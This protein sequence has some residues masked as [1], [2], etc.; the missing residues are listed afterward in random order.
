MSS[1][2]L[3]DRIANENIRGKL[4]VALIEDKMRGSFNMVWSCTKKVSR[5]NNEKINYLEVTGT[6]IGEEGHLTKF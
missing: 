6:S 4:E 3:N 2:T 5:C 1:K